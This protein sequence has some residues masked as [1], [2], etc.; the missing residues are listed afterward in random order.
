MA[1]PL[2]GLMLIFAVSAPAASRC[3]IPLLD[4]QSFARTDIAA[5]DP[6]CAA[7]QQLLPLLAPLREKA[8]FGEADVPLVVLKDSQANAF[9]R[10]E[11]PSFL[12]VTRGFLHSGQTVDS[13]RYVLAHELG[14]AIQ[15]RGPERREY[16]ALAEKTRKEKLARHGR[17][18]FEVIDA[19]AAFMRRY[20]GQADGIAQQL[21][22]S[23][24]YP[25]ETAR[26]G[27]EGYFAC[28]KSLDASVDHPAPAQ[29]LINA[30]FG[31]ELLAKHVRVA[32]AAGSVAFDGGVLRR[33][34]ADGPVD[35]PAPPAFTPAV[36]LSDYDD[37][38]VLKAGR[39]VASDL[40]VPPPPPGAGI[41][42]E[43][44]QAAAASV[45][46]YWIVRPFAA[47]VDGLMR[48]SSATE[49]VLAA[50]GTPQARVISEDAS[51]WA[52]TKRLAREG[53]LKVV[54]WLS[55]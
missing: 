13:K 9:F 8:G 50:C 24:G 1:A 28:S 45:V 38:G 37:K 27:A 29:R 25:A 20:E 16:A 2:A 22:I 14:H 36:K 6:D 51:V 4:P 3:P 21:L 18:F 43:V 44:V 30:S 46:D 34:G 40:R 31:Q 35:S 32:E 17:E 39:F 42:R 48:G 53:A 10:C 54:D 5:D 12:G 52:W 15:C 11:N 41:A 49:G 7:V 47:A 19:W 55:P 33:G 23:A 26:L